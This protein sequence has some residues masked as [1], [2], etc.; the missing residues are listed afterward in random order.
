[1]KRNKDQP[2]VTMKSL[3]AKIRDVDT[4]RFECIQ[5]YILNEYCNQLYRGEGK[6]VS[7]SER[8]NAW[9]PTSCWL[10]FDDLLRNCF[11]AQ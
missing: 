10:P 4:S 2:E 6:A 9:M 8:R 3:L 5:N 11:P 1:M 7:S